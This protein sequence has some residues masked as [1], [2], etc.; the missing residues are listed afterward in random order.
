MDG[1]SSD[2]LTI[3]DQ[4]R[5]FIDLF[6]DLFLSKIGV[7]SKDVYQKLVAFDNANRGIHVSLQNIGRFGQEIMVSFPFSIQIGYRRVAQ[8]QHLPYLHHCYIFLLLFAFEEQL[9]LLEEVQSYHCSFF[10][11][12]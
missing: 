5:I 12:M 6:N 1:K 3:F 2:F 8:I 10:W 4:L 9:C 7:V 11:I